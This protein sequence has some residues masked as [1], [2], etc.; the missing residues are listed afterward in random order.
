VAAGSECVYPPTRDRAAYSRQ[1]V[2]NLEARVQALE[3]VWGRIV[4]VLEAFEGGSSGL[5][6]GGTS[7]GGTSHPPIPMPTLPAPMQD[8]DDDEDGA[9]D[10]HS[11]EDGQI[12]QDERGN[13]RW[14]GSSNTLSLLDSFSGQPLQT[15]LSSTPH[16]HTPD[17]N[18]YFGPVAGSGVVKALPGVDEVSY[19]THR[20]ARE[21]VDAFFSDVHPTLPVVI[22]YEFRQ[23]FDA[24][25][26]RRSRGEVET[27]SQTV[28][29]RVCS[30]LTIVC[31]GLVRGICPRR[32]GSSHEPRLAAS[33]IHQ[34][35][36]GSTRRS[37]SRSD[38]V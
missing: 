5:L 36:R 24:L 31:L 7:N 10:R 1:Y 2:Q 19:P 37:R 17:R 6:G 22:E 4:P 16:T 38:L 3:G 26:D 13:Y 30:K 33:K 23:E 29:P 11:L 8:D 32:A 25:M 28:R 20:A 15:P 18:P 21:M 27:S 9:S 14:I 35:R 12:T 34:S